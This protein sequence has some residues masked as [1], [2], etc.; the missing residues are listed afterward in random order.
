MKK[1][2]TW[3]T[4]L[5]LLGAAP[6]AFADFYKYVDESGK[7]Q[8]TDNI[9]NIPDDQRKQIEAYQESAPPPKLPTAADEQVT[10]VDSRGDT[11]GETEVTAEP[12]TQV[13]VSADEAHALE[14]R[15]QVLQRE[16]EVL[17][18]ERKALDEA[19]KVRLTPMEK[20][21]LIEKI[22]D[23]NSRIKAYEKKRQAY[24]E[25]VEAYNAAVAETVSAEGDQEAAQE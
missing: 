7:V 13:G 19:A 14:Q 9:A 8:F 6:C 4:C 20:R 12:V 2:C 15:G 21:K 5:I 11:S 22:S 1:V 17:M 23:F 10:E 18:E 3:F 16:Y 25:A 24:N